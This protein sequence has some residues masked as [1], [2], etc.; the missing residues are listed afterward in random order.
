M[1]AGCRALREL[2]LGGI[3]VL[4]RALIRRA[5]RFDAEEPLSGQRAITHVALDACR[6]LAAGFGL[7]TAMTIDAARLGF[8]IGEVRVEMTHRPTGRSPR[9]FAHRGMQGV[10]ILRAALPRLVGLR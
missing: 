3:T 7:E 2:V 6:P 5:G 8:R 1:L 4:S 9:G 10:D